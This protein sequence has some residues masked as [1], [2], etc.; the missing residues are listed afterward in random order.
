MN[1][2]RINN[3]FQLLFESAV[4][5][6]EDKETLDKIKQ[7]IASDEPNNL[8]MAKKFIISQKLVGEALESIFTP[9][10][11]LKQ[12]MTLKK[13]MKA[14]I[15]DIPVGKMLEKKESLKAYTLRFSELQDNYTQLAHMFNAIEEGISEEVYDSYE[16]MYLKREGEFS[17]VSGKF[18][19][20]EQELS[21]FATKYS[22]LADSYRML[23]FE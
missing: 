3:T 18:S 23:F 20:V 6:K 22:E 9:A 5:I 8:E 16:G 15:K 1:I 13:E 2:K 11:Y 14:E 12:L 7:L 21:S 19:A 17:E 4:V 10:V